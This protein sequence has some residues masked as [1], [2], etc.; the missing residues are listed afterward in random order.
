[1]T[2]RLAPTAASE[3]NHSRAN[4]M[5]PS[6]EDLVMTHLGLA[7]QVAGHFAN[8]GEAHDDLVQ[9][10]SLAL[11]KAAERYDP[12]RGV[13]F[14]TFAVSCI[15][16]ELKRHFRDRGW[17]VRA[18]RRLQELYLEL[19]TTIDS[20]SQELG[21][22]PTVPELAVALRVSEQAVLEAL[23]AGRAYRTASLDEPDEEGQ[24]LVDQLGAADAELE[25]V[26]D[27]SV[28]S[29]A[30]D[31]MPPRDQLVLRLRFV[32]GLTQSE[33]GARLGVSQM[34]VS[35]LL[36]ASVERLRA[37]FLENGPPRTTG[38]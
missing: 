12:A 29:L 37:T 34:Q 1:M 20:M 21:R 25:Q 30:L 22:A 32:D 27:R 13:Q 14:A 10:A 17:A 35:R 11:V 16:G 33:I 3:P 38:D 18:P 31:Q 19:G 8:R 24:P 2:K 26:E 5:D 15:V 6:H 36:T 28:L 23:E 9:V 7:R 4:G